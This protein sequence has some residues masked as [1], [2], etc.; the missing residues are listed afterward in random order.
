MANTLKNHACIGVITSAHGIAGKV[1][2]KTFTE[3]PENIKSFK[4]IKD[5]SGNS[6]KLSNISF[7]NDIATASVEGVSDRNMAEKLAKTELFV[8]KSDLPETADDEFYY[9]DLVGMVAKSEGGKEVGNI[10][11]VYN[12]GAGDVI[13]IRLKST[14]KLE[15]INFNE[16][17]ILQVNQDDNIVIVNMPDVTFSQD[18]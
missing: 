10:E 16:R 18:D 13:E 6:Y 14:G 9:D 8:L 3:N 7:K 17:N 2:I 12:F 11:A 5:A 1:K 15:M 4:D